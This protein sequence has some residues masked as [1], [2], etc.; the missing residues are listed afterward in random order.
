MPIWWNAI[1]S[2]ATRKPTCGDWW[3]MEARRRDLLNAVQDLNRRANEVAK[4]IG[5]AKSPEEREARKEEGRQLRQQ[6]DA[7]QAEH[8]R[9]EA[10]I[11]AIQIDDSQHVASGR[12]GG[13]GRPGEPRSA[14]GGSPVHPALPWTASSRRHCGERH[15]GTR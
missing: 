13:N 8:D 9:L 2:T 15:C 14:A 3:N 1:A 4:S 6:K 11:T 7:T 5:Q 10:E 12:P